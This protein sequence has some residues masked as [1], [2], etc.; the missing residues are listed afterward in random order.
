MTLDTITLT[1]NKEGVFS[2]VGTALGL[3]P[4]AAVSLAMSTELAAPWADDST[5]VDV[6]PDQWLD[7]WLG[8]DLSALRM[9]RNRAMGIGTVAK[10]RHVIAI[11]VGRLTLVTKRE[12]V[13]M[14]ARQILWQPERG[15]TRFQSIVDLVDELIF[16][17]RAWWVVV[18]RDAYG[19]PS[20]VELVKYA[21]GGM[22]NDGTRLLRTGKTSV[23]AADVIEF[24]SPLGNGVLIDGAETLRR[25]YAINKAA[26]LAEDNPVPTVELHNTSPEPI[27][28]EEKEAL[29]DGWSNSRRKRGVAYTSKGVE[30]KTHGVHPE[31]LLI[32]GRKAINLEITRQM[33]ASAWIAD[34]AVEGSTLKYENRALRNWELLDLNCAPYLS[35]IAER[36]TLGDVTPRG[37][38]VE[39]DTDALTRPDEKTR[40]E[41]AKVWIEAGADPG[42]VLAREGLSVRSGGATE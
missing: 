27:S 30:V 12:G 23:P 40:A 6:T 1:P 2:R 18:E 41:T 22:N 19:W 28:P 4:S 24:P 37:W 21:E 42:E 17:P 20:W 34:V 8:G 29:L 25:A 36:L 9:T 35:A 31:Q 32:E 3:R 38:V 26:A 11:T 10:V 15:R 13:V 39:F 14:P 7:L 16:H 5:L 33:N